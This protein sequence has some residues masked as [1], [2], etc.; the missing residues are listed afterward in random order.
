MK[1][2][3]VFI[4]LILVFLEVST[5]GFSQTEKVKKP[6]KK[7]LTVKEWNT[8]SDTKTK[9]LDHVSIFNDLGLKIEEIE[10]ANYG[11]K[12]KIVYE[13]DTNKRCIQQTEYDGRERVV[14]IKKFEYNVDGTKKKQ[15]T[16]NP[17]GKLISE[18]EFEYIYK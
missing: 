18:K 8:N 15:S 9:F 11:I 14:E 7:N 10:Y 4:I 17:K 13:Y 3:I 2:N 5:E 16:Y 6:T 1:K 12:S